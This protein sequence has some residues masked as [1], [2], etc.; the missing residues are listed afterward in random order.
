MG[1]IFYYSSLSE[2]MPAV[3]DKPYEKM[4][5]TLSHMSEYAGLAFWFYFG[6]TRGRP[7][8]IKPTPR[9]LVYAAT[10]AVAYGVTD[11]VHQI[12]VPGRTFQ[13]LDLIVDTV[14]SG[15]AVLGIG[16]WG[17]R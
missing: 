1:V 2:P 15:F 8:R 7:F 11:E 14:G 9:F 5:N 12:Y 17:R 10:M 4:V 13:W 16:V 6:W 3:K